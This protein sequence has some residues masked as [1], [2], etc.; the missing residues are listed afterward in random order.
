MTK[1]K[2]AA[3]KKSG[4]KKKAGAAKAAA[5]PKQPIDAMSPARQL[6]VFRAV[7]KALRNAG[8][9]S[10]LDGLLFD[11]EVGTLICPPNTARRVICRKDP[12]GV[13]RC[14][15]QCVPIP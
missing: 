5:L 3:K 12:K 13:V 14:V 9:A 7:D 4:A 11:T 8:V 15:P 1:K 2:P 10:P 6:A